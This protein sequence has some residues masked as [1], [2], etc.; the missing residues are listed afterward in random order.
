[1][2]SKCYYRELECYH[3]TDEKIRRRIGID[4][5]YDLSKLPSQTMQEQFRAFLLD[6]GRHVSLR[7]IRLMRNRSALIWLH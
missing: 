5:Y 3:K 1:M 7:T 2:E 6:R 4:G